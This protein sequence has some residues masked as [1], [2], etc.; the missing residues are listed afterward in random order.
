MAGVLIDPEALVT[1][2]AV[3][4]DKAAINGWPCRLRTEVLPAPHA[5]PVLPAG[6]GAVY[7]FA[8]TD[9]LP[10]PC[11]AGTVLKVGR[12]GAR[13]EARSGLSTTNRAPQDRP[14]RKAC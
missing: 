12:I 4:A 3:S 14:W 11:E 10:A 6:H 7:A 5:P 1:D 8:L 13:S 9:A 2:F